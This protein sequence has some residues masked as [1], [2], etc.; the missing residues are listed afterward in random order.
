MTTHHEHVDTIVIGAGQTGLAT[1]YHLA[2]AGQSFVVLDE[3]DRVGDGWRARYDSLRLY[4]PAKYDGLPGMRFPAP[5][6]TFPSGHQMAD[7]L[8]QYAHRFALPVRG[9]LAVDGLRRNDGDDGWVVTAGSQTFEATH[10]VAATGAQR[11]PNVPDFA[12]ELDPQITQLHSS[13]YRTPSQL[14]DGAV[15]VVGA[16]HSG[17]DLA[18]ETARD[19]ETTLV[20]PHR[21][22]IPIDI[23]GRPARVVTRGLWFAANHVLTMRTPI[24]RKMQKEV[25]EHGGPLLR[26]KRAHLADAGVHRTQ[27]RVAGVEGGRPV[28]DDGTVVDV[29]NVIWCTGFRRDWDWIT[30]RIT[31][32]DGWPAQERGVSTAAPDLYFVGVTFQYSF[33][34]MLV[35]GAGR[36]AQYVAR[37]IVR[38]ARDA[39]LVPAAA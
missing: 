13:E 9:G 11:L 15:L 12:T 38:R 31:G 34:S 7:Y 20:G 23:E 14:A 39:A 6:Y 30:P 32:A 21:G 28:L 19:H 4:S 5:R 35:G 10:V 16:A 26:V 8:E 33:A 25:R 29:A 37:H 24:G 36:D 27:A 22:E 1:A 17:A 3:N 18:L 2:K